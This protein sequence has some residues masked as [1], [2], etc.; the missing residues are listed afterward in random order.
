VSTT[1]KRAREAGLDWV[2]AE[3]LSEP[4]LERRLYRMAEGDDACRPLP[5]FVWLH[6]E[7]QKR[8]VT[9][10]LLHLEY[11]EQHPEGYRYTQFCEYYRRWCRKR[12]LSMRQPHRAGEKL[13]VDYAGKKPR[14]VNPVTGEEQ[15]VELFVAVLGASSFTYVEATRSQRSADFIAS[16]TRALEFFRG[17]PELVIPD[18]LKSGVVLACRYEP[19]L[20][21]T[22][23][24]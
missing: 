10:E 1:L 6:T 5:D 14:L 18:Q 11:L 17:V 19:G 3:A 21:R 15:E 20:Q 24:E 13:F 2:A 16:H 4:E 7:R 12:R 22:Y 8:G 9:L 23:A